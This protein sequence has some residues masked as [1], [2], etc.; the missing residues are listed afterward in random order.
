MIWCSASC[1]CTSLPNSLGLPALSLADDLGVRL[2]QADQLS[3]KLG[4]AVEDSRL[5][6]P[7][8]PAHSLGHGLQPF[9]QLAHPAAAAGR[10]SFDFLQRCANRGESAASR[11][12]VADILSCASAPLPA[13]C[14][15]GLVRWRSPVWSPCASG[16][17]L[18]S[19]DCP[20]SFRSVSWSA[21][22]P[23]RRRSAS[24]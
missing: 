14:D 3:R 22:A 23:A 24:R 11:V 9:A 10:Q 12:A 1:N 19:V 7:H 17:A 21:S 5:G 15:G 8:H 6:L 20:P 4:H 2:K 16:C 18:S 13:L